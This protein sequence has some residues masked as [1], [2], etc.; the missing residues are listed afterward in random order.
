MFWLMMMAV[1]FYG[2]C[3][4]V[5]YLFGDAAMVFV[6]WALVIGSALFMISLPVGFYLMIRFGIP[7]L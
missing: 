4:S 5:R 3:F 1:F 7:L 2:T 6:S